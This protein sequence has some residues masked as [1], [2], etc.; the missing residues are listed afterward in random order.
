MILRKSSIF[1]SDT[2]R[3]LCLYYRRMK[4]IKRILLPQI[5]E[6]YRAGVTF[7]RIA[8]DVGRSPDTISRWCRQYD[9]GLLHEE[10]DLPAPQKQ[11]APDTDESGRG[12]K[13]NASVPERE[14]LA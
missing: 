11:D 13:G 8:L 3:S 4:I 9:A 5:I 1:T 6:K 14:G 7:R 12:D 10:Y 2:A